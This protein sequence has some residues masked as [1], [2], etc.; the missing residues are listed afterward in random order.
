MASPSSKLLNAYE[1][2]QHK[3]SEFREVLLPGISHYELF[4]DSANSIEDIG[5]TVT[6]IW[7]TSQGDGRKTQNLYG[8]VGVEPHLIP[9]LIQVNQAKQSFQKAVQAYRKELGNPTELLYKRACELNKA[10]EEQGL[11]R[12]HLKQAYRLLPVV[13]KTPNKVRFSW[14]TSGRSLKKMSVADAESRLLK[15]D[16]SQL[17]IQLQLEALGKI[18][19][20]SPLVQIQQQ[21]PV[22]RANVVW[23]M[24]DDVTRKA[25][26][27]PLPLFFP[28]DDKK[29]FPAY[30]KPPLEPPEQRTRNL[31]S[32]L[33]I[34][35]EPF[36]PSLRIHRYKNV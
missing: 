14:Y 8:L 11:A 21:V 6:N 34:E 25:K 16:I 20:S 13:E 9:L 31:R 18:P 27:C 17:H 24:K 32:D 4:S 29:N 19:N 36:L 10:L 35:P 12:L 1:L 26:N 23:T 3:L 5:N 2:L 22:M 30:N 33:L 28:L 15:M 7:F